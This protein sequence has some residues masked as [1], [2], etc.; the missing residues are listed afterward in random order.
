MLSWPDS[1]LRLQSLSRLLSPLCPSFFFYKLFPGSPYF[2][3]SLPLLSIFPPINFPFF[4]HF[5]PQAL[6]SSFSHAGRHIHS[7]LSVFAHYPTFPNFLTCHF[8]KASPRS[9]LC[10]CELSPLSLAVPLYSH[11]LHSIHLCLSPASPDSPHPSLLL[12]YSYPLSFL[13]TSLCCVSWQPSFS[14]TLRNE[15][16][17]TRYERCQYKYI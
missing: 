9:P 4:F 7:F 16:T 11:T 15:N 17:H 10:I 2:C 5:S 8:S 13:S 3:T 14:L 6:V 1:F 12:P